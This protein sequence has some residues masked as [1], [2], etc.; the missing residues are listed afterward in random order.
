MLHVNNNF[1][2]GEPSLTNEQENALAEIEEFIEDDDRQVF[3]LSGLAG[4][5][6]TFLLTHIA[7]QYNHTALCTLTGKAASILRRR[8]GLNA[9]TV[10]SFFYR[11]TEVMRDK[12]GRQILEFKEQ[13]DQGG[14]LGQL[15]LLDECSMIDE[16]IG[17]DLLNTGC[18]LVATGDPGQLPPVKGES[19]FQTADFTLTEIHRQALGNPIIRQ[20]HAVRT[21]GTYRADGDNFK[22]TDDVGEDDVRAAGVVLCWRNKTKDAWNDYCRHICGLVQPYP[23]PGEPLV[24]LRNASRYGIFNGGVY[25][26]VQPFLERDT[27]ITIDVDG[28]IKTIPNVKFT[29]V[30]SR[31]PDDV[32]PVTSF[33]FGYAMTVHKAQGSEWDRV[34]LIDEY[35]RSE[36]RQKWLYTAITRAAE[37]IIVLHR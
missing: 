30:P 24:C 15:V 35:N 33:G 12:R 36:E 28:E 2:N 22:V 18:K 34:L 9:C 4:T 8:T 19:F 25:T 17:R 7:Q 29:G 32:E 6:K 3:N 37:Q 27:Q 11:L 13:H 16:R 23:Q 21:G 5:G 1:D 10:H 26:L 14:L 20:A 31:L